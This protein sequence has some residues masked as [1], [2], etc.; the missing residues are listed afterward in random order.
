MLKRDLRLSHQ[1][2]RAAL[3]KKEAGQRSQDIANRCLGLPIWSASLYHIFLSI[4]HKREVDTS[5]LQAGIRQRGGAIAVPRVEAKGSLSHIL[6]REDTP[7]RPNALGIPEPVGGLEVKEKQIDV[8]FLPLLA[9]DKNGFR[10]GYGGGFYDRF[11]SLCRPEVVKIGLSF[12]P[13][14]PAIA[15]LHAGDIPMDYCVTPDIVYAF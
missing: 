11:L 15:D 13:A 7:L 14:V 9:F 10:V 8:V 6:L 12:F 1:S 5:F 3:S 4:P 2:L